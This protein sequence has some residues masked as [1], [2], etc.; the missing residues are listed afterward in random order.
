[1][2]FFGQLTQGNMSIEQFSAKIN[3]IGK[4]AGMTDEQKREQFI[5]GL[6]P[7]NQ[8]NLRMMAKFHE[9]QE[10]IT[11]ALAEAEKFMKQG[12][13]S[14]YSQPPY[15][16]S[17][18]EITYG[19]PV[20]PYR[21]YYT[22]NE[23][24]RIVDERIS[25]KQSKPNTRS[26]VKAWQNYE[27]IPTDD[28][29]NIVNARIE[30]FKQEAGGFIKNRNYNEALL[31]L[32]LLAED[33]GYPDEAPRDVPTLIDYL[34]SEIKKLGHENFFSRSASFAR[35]QRR[36]YKTKKSSKKTKK[37]VRHCSKCGKA[38]HTK[39]NCTKK[40]K[41]SKNVN[42][43]QSVE[44]EDSSLSSSSEEETESS[45]SEETETDISS[46]EDEDAYKCYVEKKKR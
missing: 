23:I 20:E 43:A 44:T 3:K 21:K 14:S 2:V 19:Q 22:E 11:K 30:K 34:K 18:S 29:E 27:N 10:N 42:F 37:S 35:P 13:S 25:S 24:N 12:G 1:M 5:R 7:M 45:E 38:G 17:G 28:I 26:N 9:T 41:A 16:S 46:S 33:F 32:E 8:Y 39:T 4:I 40:K 6:N 31:Q 36:V 15:S